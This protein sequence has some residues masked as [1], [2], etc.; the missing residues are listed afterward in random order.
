M[1]V[2][3]FQQVGSL[4]VVGRIV[5]TDKIH[6]ARSREEKREVTILVPIL[7]SKVTAEQ[8]VSTEELKP[9]N[10]DKIIAQYPGAWEDYLARK[11]AEAPA[12]TPGS[13][14]LPPKRGMPIEKAEFLKR[15][16][17]LSLKTQGFT[18]VEQLA[19]IDD[20]QMNKL[21]PGARNWKKK[22]ATLLKD[23][24]AA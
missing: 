24:A 10:R 23:K 4:R 16:T 15:E 14:E 18:T 12:T 8:E 13:N 20:G 7:I 17:M 6:A 5:D 11:A 1:E 19:E 22:A 3:W 9:H 21:G 2:K